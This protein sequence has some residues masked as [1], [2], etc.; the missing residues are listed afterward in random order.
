MI[1]VGLGLHDHRLDDVRELTQIVPQ[2]V[3]I[4][5]WIAHGVRVDV[6]DL[7]ALLE[8][9]SGEFQG[10]PVADLIEIGVLFLVVHADGDVMGGQLVSLIE[11]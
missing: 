3:R 10:R 1:A 4:L 8:G 9:S 6:C 2:V 5:A 7:E 11:D